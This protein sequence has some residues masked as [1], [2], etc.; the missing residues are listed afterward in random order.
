MCYYQ[1]KMYKE[2]SSLLKEVIEIEPK[3]TKA[4]KTLGSIYYKQKDYS[5]AISYFEKVV[6]SEPFNTEL[7][8]VLAV[9]YEKTGLSEKANDTYRIIEKH[10]PQD[11]LLELSI[12]ENKSNQKD[13]DGAR[14]I[15]FSVL[16][17]I[18]DKSLIY[19]YIANTYFNENKYDTAL[20]YYNKVYN[21][22]PNL[23]EVEELLALSYY[24]SNDM[25]NAISYFDKVQ[26][27]RTPEINNYIGLAYL[28]L[29][30]YIKAKTYFKQATLLDSDF[31]IA[32]F[33]LGSN[34]LYV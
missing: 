30:S 11:P 1:Q 22:N 10:N 15:Y 29:N 21:V 28:K 5:T 23:K 13:Y 7:L 3:N 20:N 8:N 2:A 31:G 24:Y 6:A 25:I 19:Y 27:K 32:Y 16:D 33:N 14:T 18:E 4:N 17:N 34:Q 12:A 9:C 26:S